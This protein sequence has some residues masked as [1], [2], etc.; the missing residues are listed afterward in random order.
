MLKPSMA[1]PSS[2]FNSTT[3]L[4]NEIIPWRIQQGLDS[5]TTCMLR[6]IPNK[7]SQKM[8]MDFID[9]THRGTYDFIYLRMDF[10]NRC[11]VGY[12]FINFIDQK[13]D[14][15]RSLVSLSFVCCLLLVACVDLL[16][17]SPSVSRG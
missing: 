2:A 10:K 13:Y 11:N 14:A 12:S 16:F 17:V 15:C 8:L 4:T 6:N 5:R 7:Y 1:M 3:P 9:V